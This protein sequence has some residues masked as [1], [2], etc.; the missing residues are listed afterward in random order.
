MK[1]G[2]NNNN[3]RFLFLLLLFIVHSYKQKLEKE[4]MSL[5]VSSDQSDPLSLC[6][7]TTGGRHPLLGHKV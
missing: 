7:L 2:N 5:P 3:N 6:I 1:V 4:L